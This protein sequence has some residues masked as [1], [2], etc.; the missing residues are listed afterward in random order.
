MARNDYPIDLRVRRPERSSRGWAALTILLIKFVALIPHFVILFFLGIAQ[1]AVAFIAQVVCAVKGVYPPGM[2]AFVAGVLRWNTRVVAFTLSLTDRYPP[3][4]LQ[5]D[6]SYAVDVVLEPPARSSRAYALFTVLV[7]IV[8]VALLVSLVS[9]DPF[10]LVSYASGG[11]L[12]RQLAAVPHLVV[13][14]FLGMA[15]I[16]IWLL[17]QWAILFAAVF[18]RGMFDVVAGFVRWSSRV[19][20]YALGLS[21]RYPPFTL[22]ASLT[23]PKDMAPDQTSSPP[24]WPATTVPLPPAPP[25]PPPPPL[26][27]QGPQG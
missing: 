7:E 23:V 20:G 25:P 16:V 8:F 14:V 17:V 21:D 11:L 5:P 1:V 22:E 9:D 2:F 24:P 27:P 13:L 10:D 6:D 12:L 18:P 15:A 3:F 4:S 26:P 19:N